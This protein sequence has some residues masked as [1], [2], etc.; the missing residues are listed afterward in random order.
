MEKVSK[1]TEGMFHSP[2]P[3]FVH[4]AIQGAQRHYAKDIPNQTVIEEKEAI[5]KLRKEIFPER[6]PEAISDTDTSIQTPVISIP[7][8]IQEWID[9]N[10]RK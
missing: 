7:K 4:E 8:P 2:W 6:L 1:N 10:A 9:P 5:A 3:A